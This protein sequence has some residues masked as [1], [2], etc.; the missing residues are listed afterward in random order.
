ME[1]L[2]KIIIFF[3]CVFILGFILHYVGRIFGL[4]FS[5]SFFEQLR[6]EKGNGSK[7]EDT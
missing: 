7:K 6:K 1:L 3:V 5:K 4:G 2:G